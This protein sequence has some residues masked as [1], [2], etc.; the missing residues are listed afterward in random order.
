MTD[1]PLLIKLV[2]TNL[3]LLAIFMGVM[4]IRIVWWP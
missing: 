1:A 3:G 4:C 2:M